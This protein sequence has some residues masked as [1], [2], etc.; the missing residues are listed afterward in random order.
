MCAAYSQEMVSDIVLQAIHDLTLSSV[1][2]I[3]VFLVHTLNRSTIMVS[4]F[5]I[6]LPASGR[7]HGSLD[8]VQ[9]AVEQKL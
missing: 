8:P 4:T 9:A 3:G 2:P 6:H 7:T 5:V 1:L